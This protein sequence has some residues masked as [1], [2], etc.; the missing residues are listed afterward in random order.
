MN[1]EKPD[2][3]LASQSPRRRELLQQ[4][5]VNY[6]TLTVNVP[7]APLSGE[8]PEAYVQRLAREKSRAGC[9]ELIVR[10]LA[11]APV[12]GADTIVV[13]DD[14][15]L[16]KPQ[17]EQHAAAMLRLLS[18]RTHQVLTAVALSDAMHSET[19]LC[20][21]H[22]KFRVLEEREIS[23]YWQTGE[24][25]DKAGG[26][27]IQGLGAVFISELRG[28]YTGVVGLPIETTV[29]LLQQFGVP[30]WQPVRNIHE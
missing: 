20:T 1:S 15:I 5:G 16:E 24:P 28:S 19:R 4:I 2:L 27:G 25:H 12:L 29:S 9:A 23:D 10:S 13:C 11:P 7:E 18:G 26:Y 17:D 22:V 14:A 21:T 8:R 6:R 30:W 3:Y